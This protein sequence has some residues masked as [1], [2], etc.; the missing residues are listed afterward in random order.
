MKKT[1][2]L[3]SIIAGALAFG[4]L[5]PAGSSLAYDSSGQTFT[6]S[7]QLGDNGT[8]WEINF[9]YNKFLIDED[10]TKTLHMTR[11]HIAKVS[12]ESGTHADSDAKGNWAGIEVKH[13]GS[14]VYY[15]LE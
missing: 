9:G 3:K 6:K 7:W 15:F 5:L 2:K 14:K 13:K 11:S 1:T 8:N 4:L 12:N 10:F